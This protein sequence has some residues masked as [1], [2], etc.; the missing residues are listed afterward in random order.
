MDLKE[1]LEYFK[2]TE[3]SMIIMNAVIEEQNEILDSRA[4]YF[5]AENNKMNHHLEINRSYHS[6]ELNKYRD[7]HIR[8]MNRDR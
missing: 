4:K 3:L 8:L 7:D 1:D 6:K 2:K 5:E